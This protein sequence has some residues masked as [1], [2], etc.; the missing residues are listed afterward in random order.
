MKYHYNNS[1]IAKRY[2]KALFIYGNQIGESDLVYHDLRMLKT[3]IDQIPNLNFFINNKLM[4]I[5]KKLE[6]FFEIIKFSSIISSNLIKLLFQNNRIFILQAIILEY[7]NIYNKI[8]NIYKIQ[9]I[10][11]I[12]IDILFQKKIINKLISIYK[13]DNTFKYE[14]DHKINHEI[15]GGICIYIESKKLDLT[16]KTMMFHIKNNFIN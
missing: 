2:A 15:I 12:D 13:L 9:I 5:N 6:I 7:E 3:Y 1:L 11:A 16:I 14:I 10:T 8:N 4:L